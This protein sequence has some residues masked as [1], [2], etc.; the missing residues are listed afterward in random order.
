MKLLTALRYLWIHIRNDWLRSLLSM[1]SV[2][3]LVCVYLM[4]S[5]MINDLQRLGRSLLRFPESLLLVFSRNAVFPPDSHVDNAEL[6][7]YKDKIT[8][9][10]GDDAVVE[11]LSF[12][13]RVVRIS[14]HSVI[15]A[16]AD[17]KALDKLAKLELIEGSWPTD[18]GQAL[19]NQDFVALTG[20]GLGEQV[21]IYGS[22]LVISGIINSGLWQNAL[23]LFNYEQAMHFYQLEDDFQIG[24]LMLANGLDPTRVQQS[25]QGLYVN[26]L[27][28][29]VYLHDHYYA[30]TQNA[31]QGFISVYGV[32]QLIGLLLITF[33][34]YNAAALALAEHQREI[35]MSRVIGF[36]GRQMTWLLLLRT[37]LVVYMAF[38]LGW[39]AAAIIT[40]MSFYLNPFSM[41]GVMIT[42]TFDAKDVLAAFGW[43][44]LC[45]LFGVLFA[46]LRYDPLKKGTQLRSLSKGRAI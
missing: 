32:V 24:G 20:I 10:F 28:C 7:F 13:Y 37:Y 19:V 9:T 46:S 25:L 39:L 4:S 44:S 2:A 41:S 12:F 8:E 26:E 31:F 43:M 5:G 29:H 36:S 18:F 6:A 14:E 16:G 27:C 42:L 21:R 1:L 17:Y 34:A 30:L 33:G 22:D 40:R 38:L 3:A 11:T 45:T 15:T 35:I 23:V